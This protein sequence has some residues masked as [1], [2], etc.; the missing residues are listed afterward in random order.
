M[1]TN[2]ESPGIYPIPAARPDTI[3]VRQCSSGR[4]EI[5]YNARNPNI[6]I[7]NKWKIN[8]ISN[9]S[10]IILRIVVLF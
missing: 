3:D 2:K 10:K 8:E 1:S 9:V 4:Q 7:R 5:L 6:E